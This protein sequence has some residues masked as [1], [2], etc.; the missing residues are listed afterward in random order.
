MGEST[1]LTVKNYLIVGLLII[2]TFKSYTQPKKRFQNRLLQIGLVPGVGTNGIHSGWFVNKYSLNIF[3]GFSAANR[4]VEI[5]GISNLNTQYA[6]GIQLAGIA[7]VV[8]S[9]T[10]LNLTIGEERAQIREGFESNMTGIQVAGLLN[11]I[12]DNV[13]GIQISGGLNFVHKGTRGLQL[14]GLSNMVGSYNI[15]IQIATLY[16][17]AMTSSSGMQLALLSNLTNGE[18]QGIQISLL[19]K[20]WRINGKNSDPPS[21]ITG[22]QIGLVNL[23]SK[24]NGLQVGLVNRARKMRGTQIGLINFYSTAPNKTHGKNGTPIG[25]LNFGSAGGHQRAYTTETF[26]YNFEFTTGNCYNCTNTKS[27]M[28]LTGDYLIMN[29]NA[30]IFSYNPASLRSS[31]D[32]QW[33]IGYGFEK[34]RYNKN[35]MS[36]EDPRNAK[37]FISYGISFKHVSFKDAIADHLNLLTSIDLEYGRKIRNKLFTFYLYGGISANAFV[38]NEVSPIAPE[39]ISYNITSAEFNYDFWPGYEVGVHLR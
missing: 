32:P 39:N 13:S 21:K 8:G 27:G 15:G 4:Y 18:M 3:S 37:K 5:A 23:A 20:A 7:N 19:N 38:S 25:L 10:F 24:M 17:V 22:W 33:A 11:L 6:T 12:R 35:S 28:P 36:A 9:N 14:A 30:L 1:F 29:Q 31:K 16:N 2:V 26:F 34:V